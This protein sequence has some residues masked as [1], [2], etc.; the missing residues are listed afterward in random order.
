MGLLSLTDWS[1]LLFDDGLKGN[2]SLTLMH[3]Y[4]SHR[5]EVL[6]LSA[7]DRQSNTFDRYTDSRPGIS[8]PVLS[9][10][11]SHRFPRVCVDSC[12]KVG[13]P[14]GHYSYLGAMILSSVIA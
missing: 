4:P 7:C 13:M 10:A 6:L 11:I 2:P 9:P 5:C 12:T 8:S 14:I 1:F 3:F